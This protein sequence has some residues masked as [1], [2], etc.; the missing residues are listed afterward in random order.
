MRFTI[1]CYSCERET[2]AEQVGAYG[3]VWRLSGLCEFCRQASRSSGDVRPDGLSAGVDAEA[4]GGGESREERLSR[5]A[6]RAISRIYAY[7]NVEFCGA[8]GSGRESWDRAW[9]AVVELDKA[10]AEPGAP[11]SR[12]AAE[13]VTGRYWAEHLPPLPPA[14][15]FGEA[16]ASAQT[17]CR[18]DT[19]ADAHRIARLLNAEE[20]GA[21][22]KREEPRSMSDASDA[23]HYAL[24]SALS[25]GMPRR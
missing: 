8:D 22:E 21:P 2:D 14:V 3:E 5:L 7:R 24:V 11:E 15:W 4:Q 17:V 23:W 12:E 6:I 18:C 13:R 1:R 20:V 25:K 9:E 19:M 16:P 10:L